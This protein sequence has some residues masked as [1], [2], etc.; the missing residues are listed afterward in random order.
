ML[1]I[2]CEILS[3]CIAYWSCQID[4]MK[5]FSVTDSTHGLVSADKNVTSGLN[6]FKLQENKQ[7]TSIFVLSFVLE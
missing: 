1:S 5:R 2:V 7:N 4:I 6:Q 3:I